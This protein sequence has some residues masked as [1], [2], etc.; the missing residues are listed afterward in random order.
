MCF[1]RDWGFCLLVC[2]SRDWGFCLNDEATKHEL[3][4]DERPPGVIYDADHQCRLQYGDDASHCDVDVR[5]ASCLYILLSPPI[6][7]L[8]YVLYMLR[9]LSVLCAY[10]YSLYVMLLLV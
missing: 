10:M 1:S 2:F 5:I 6:I 3:Q 9:D 8:T 4:F 7:S